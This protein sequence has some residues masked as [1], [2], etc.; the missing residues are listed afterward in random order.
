VASP[1]PSVTIPPLIELASGNSN[2]QFNLLRFSEDQAWT[3][4]GVDTLFSDLFFLN[5]GNT[6]A[7]RYLGLENLRPLA[8]HQ[9]SPNRAT[10][11]FS[12]YGG[13]LSLSLDSV[14]WGGAAGSF[15]ATRRETVTLTNTGTTALEVSLFKYIDYDLRFDGLV[16]NDTVAFAQN[17]LMQTDPSRALATLS[18]D[19]TPTAV[20][21]G[22]YGQLLAQFYNSP[23]VD[24]QNSPAP[25]VN[26][27]VTAAMQFDRILNPGESASFQFFLAVQR[28]PKTK[29][30]PE[31]GT[32][33]ALLGL[34]LFGMIAARLRCRR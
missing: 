30:V 3:V 9:S 21:L 27:D 10:A 1:S 8:F 16:N 6:P 14:L 18:V 4:D 34:G 20:Q 23:A 7:R 32:A 2:Y 24:L 26:R 5:L 28:Q 22:P 19:Q 29:A 17:T 31:P 15:S 11:A 12:T 13:G 25:L 33:T